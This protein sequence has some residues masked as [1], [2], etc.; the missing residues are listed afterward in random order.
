MKFLASLALVGM[1]IVGGAATQ[2]TALA[3]QAP[4]ADTAARTIA[5]SATPL[6]ISAQTPFSLGADSPLSL[7]GGNS[8]ATNGVC[9]EQHTECAAE[10]LSYVGSAKGACLRLCLFLYRECLAGG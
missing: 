7:D 10:C 6:S 5:S 4:Q 1:L 8:D 9:E 2:Q 3:D